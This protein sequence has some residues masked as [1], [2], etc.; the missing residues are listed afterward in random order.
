M[1]R[2]IRV[3]SNVIGLLASINVFGHVYCL[4]YFNKKKWLGAVIALLAAGLNFYGMREVFSTSGMALL[5]FSAVLIGVDLIGLI[6]RVFGKGN[7]H[8]FYRRLKKRG[9]AFLIAG[10]YVVYG[11]VNVH[12]VRKTEYAF[13]N[14]NAMEP[15]SI[16]LVSDS[17]LG[18]VMDDEKLL[19]VLR[20]IV[21]G[22]AD[23]IVL[24]GDIVDESTDKDM[25]LRFA[26]GMKGIRAPKGV[27]FVFG[28]HDASRYGGALTRMEM[29]TALAL[30]GVTVLT[31][32]SVLLDGWLRIC[33][34][35][36]ANDNRMKPEALLAG[37]DTENEYILLIDHQPAET[38][39][40]AEAGV[41]LMVSGH[42]HNG[43]I[44][45]VNVIS[46][47]FNINEIEY[48]HKKI[49]DM[50]AV[51]S[52]GV[53]G[54]GSAFRTAGKSEYVIIKISPVG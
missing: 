10:I 53:A 16:A 9:L 25:F 3:F 6:L 7:P 24:A 42:T 50:N 13:E 14:E 11:L 18:T 52:S 28:N 33:G 54:W 48:G 5:T 20:K 37:A 51:V 44:F 23:V 17:H 12:V 19:S 41:D 46:V 29:E 36:D 39:E 21:S 8:A 1:F 31:D 45:P 40:C 47:L 27:Y 4:G 43:Q 49:G 35:K 26:E 15:L 30:S 2:L 22:G 32:E 34:R 38:K